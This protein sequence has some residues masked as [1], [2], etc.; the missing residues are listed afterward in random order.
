[1]HDE[2]DLIVPNPDSPFADPA[3]APASTPPPVAS[4]EGAT[5]RG[6]AIRAGIVAGSAL[7]VVLGAAVAMGAS[8]APSAA[9]NGPTG[10]GGPGPGGVPGHGGPA[11]GLGHD[12]L[13][14]EHGRFRSVFGQIT[15]T[16]IDGNAVS[17][18]TADGWTRTI[19]V[20]SATTITKGG[21]AAT[22]ADL[23]VG[24]TIGL[25][26]TRNDD[27]T[28]TVN[29]IEIL[30]PTVAGTVTAVGSD[31]ITITVRGGSTQTIGTTASTTYRV[32]RSDGSRND[33]TVGSTIFATGERASDGRLTAS[34]VT[35]IPP[36]VAGTVSALN[37]NAIT[38]TRRD[39]TSMTIHV[40]P[41]ARIAVAGVEA[42]TVGDIKVG[43]ILVAEGVQ[44]SDG[45]LD[46]SA[47]RAGQLKDRGRGPDLRP[48]DSPP[49][50]G[51]S[52]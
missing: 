30:V 44:R 33:V 1:M 5:G 7:V 25:G 22:L 47:I 40:A 49:P 41:D 35:V 16:A 18:K 12:N 14:G 34:S 38:I 20:T 2:P 50:S 32:G 37:G 39:G 45:S 3:S 31:T 9:P 15:V 21:A 6:R 28:F 13:G 8:P 17:L 52:G 43:M 10:S 36:R 24:D 4:F 19:Q 29:R 42:A 11:L 23:A 51:T 26:Q 46:A 27:G 48:D